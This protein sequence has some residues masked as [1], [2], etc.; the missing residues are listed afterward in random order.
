MVKFYYLLNGLSELRIAKVPSM[1]K[2]ELDSY[3]KPIYW[4]GFTGSPGFFFT[5]SVS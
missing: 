4:T 2:D 3:F 5:F 1:F